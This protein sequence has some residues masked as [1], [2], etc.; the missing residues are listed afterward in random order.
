MERWPRVVI[1]LLNWR[2]PAEILA[3][4]RSVERLDYPAVDVIVVDNGSHNG[5]VEEIRAE[6][7]RVWLIENGANLGFAGGCNIGLAASLERGADYVLL[8]NDDTEVAPD[9]LRVLVGVAESDDA[10]GIVGPRIYYFDRPDVIWSAGGTVDRLGQPGHLAVDRVDDGTPTAMRDVDYVTGCAML[11]KR[12]VI[13]TVGPLDERFFA[14]FEETEWCSRA[15]RAGFRTVVVPD[16]RVWHKIA[17]S[18]RGDSPLYIYLMTRN[19]LLYLRATFAGGVTIARAV[20]QQLRTAA[21]WFLRPC[22]RAR[23]T[24]T[25]PLLRGVGDYLLGRFGAPPARL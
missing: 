7:A 24:L 15:R 23:R 18:D 3:C 6:H 20:L 4:L 14:Y 10:I 13:E 17:A 22:H 19:R 8:L 21:S 9:L 1:V 12:R 2:R 25:W 5:S 11:I 16:G